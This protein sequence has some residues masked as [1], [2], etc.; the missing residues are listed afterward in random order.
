[1]QVINKAAR[2]NRIV[3]NHQD[4]CN[5]GSVW[6]ASIEVR[7]EEEGICTQTAHYGGS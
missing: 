1:M 7:K 2:G 3:E 5:V 6:M 4:L